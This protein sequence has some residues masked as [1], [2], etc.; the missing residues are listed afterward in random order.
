MKK[1][2]ED[3]DFTTE[4][5]YFEYIVESYINGQKK[6]AKELFQTMPLDK[7]EYFLFEWLDPEK[8]SHLDL[9][10]YLM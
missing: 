5:Q 8:D 1:L 7:I 4:S 2:L 10:T 3:L 9:I 6:Q